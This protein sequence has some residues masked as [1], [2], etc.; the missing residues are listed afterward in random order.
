MKMMKYFL[1]NILPLL[2]IILCT[3]PTHGQ[4]IYR[5]TDS[6]RVA[7]GLPGIGYVILKSDTILEIKT[8]GYKRIDKPDS[9]TLSSRFHIGSNTKAITAFVAAHLVEEGKIRWETGFFEI[10]PELLNKAQKEYHSITLGD[11]LS[12]R[13]RV[14]PLTSGREIAQIPLRGSRAEKQIQF[15]ENIFSRNPEKPENDTSIVYSNAGYAL[16]SMMMER[17]TGKTYEELIE[18]Y[19]NEK[20]GLRFQIGWPHIH[21]PHQTYGHFGKRLGFQKLVP[22]TFNVYHLNELIKPAGDINATLTDYAKFIQLFLK[23]LK[24][25]NNILKAST[26]AHL[27]LGY[28]EYACGWAHGTHDNKTYATHNGSA[29][30]YFCHTFIIK[31]NDLAFIVVSNSAEEEAEK[32]IFEIRKL[33]LKKYAQ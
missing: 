28:P 23:G 25:E 10:F 18:F 20:V 16:A 33:I 24:G 6:I 2:V 32:A 11:L 21:D 15:A 30:T 8:A 29:G 31:E 13:A 14:A 5:V 12:H 26:Y 7:Y 22:D 27:L 4:D 9:L 17:I 19:V 1:Q 3:G